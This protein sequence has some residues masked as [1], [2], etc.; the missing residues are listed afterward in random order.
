M[1]HSF[2]RNQFKTDGSGMCRQM[3]KCALAFFL[4]DASPFLR[5]GRMP[6]T[7]GLV[8]HLDLLK[9]QGTI[10]TVGDEKTILA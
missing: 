6:E 9:A 8:L 1:S 3:A 10:K 2:L 4:L 7:R 5:C